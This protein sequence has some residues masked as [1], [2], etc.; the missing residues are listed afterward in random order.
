MK[1]ILRT[2][3]LGTS[4]LVGALSTVF[5]GS[6][7][8]GGGTDDGA[9]AKPPATNVPS[10][11]AGMKVYI[12]PETGELLE[13]PPAGAEPLPTEAPSTPSQELEQVES[14]VP[15]GGVMVRGRFQTPLE[16]TIGPEGKPVVRHRDDSLGSRH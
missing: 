16:A 12:D 3:I 15:G 2:S 14:P 5:I 1:R 10:S 11:S 9:A 8:Q 6:D 13:Q 7:A 4:V